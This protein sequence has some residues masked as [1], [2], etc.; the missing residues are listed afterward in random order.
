[1]TDVM[2]A[3]GEVYLDDIIVPGA[4][5]DEYLNNLD[6]VMQAL[7]RANL[8]VNPEKCRLGLRQIEYVGHTIDSTGIH[9][10]KEKLQKVVQMEKPKYAKQLKS[11]LGLAN[12]FRDHIA[13]HSTTVAPLTRMLDNYKRNTLLQWTAETEQAFEDIKDKIN[14]CP[15]LFFC[16]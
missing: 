12:Y 14:N 3:A 15:K 6:R 5:E 9:F 16:R 1:M 10:S 8:T 13:G 11:F 4:E 7:D 2:Y